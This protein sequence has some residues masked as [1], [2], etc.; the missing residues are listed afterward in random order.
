M[1]FRLLLLTTGFLASTLAGCGREELAPWFPLPLR[2]ECTNAP[3][4]VVGRFFEWDLQY[5]GGLEPLTWEAEGLPPGLMI[6]DGIISGTPTEAGAFD[7]IIRVTDAD[8][9]VTEFDACGRLNVNPP[10]RPDIQCV[11]ETG[12]MPGGFVGVPYNF[13]VNAPGGATPYTWEV[14]GLAPGLTLTPDGASLSSATISGTPTTTGVYP[15]T[16]SVTDAEGVV[17][18]ATCGDLIINDPIS[19]DP[20]ELLEV[21]PDGCVPLGVTLQDLINEGIIFGG[22][23]TAISC[24]FEASRGHGAI[25]GNQPPGLSLD[26]GTCAW[27]GTVSSNLPFGIYG[28][29]TTFSQSGQNAYVPHCAPQ[30]VK[31][32]TAYT[33]G[34]QDGG[35]DATFKPGVAWL[36]GGGNFTFGTD[37][38]DPQVTV[39]DNVNACNGNTCFYA[40]V[41]QYN[42]LSQMASVSANPNAKFPAQGFD[43]FTHAVRITDGT[44]DSLRSRAY[45]ANV[46]FDYC[47]ANNGD[48][49]GNNATPEERAILVRM[50]GGNSNYYFSLVVLPQN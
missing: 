7:F 28:Y 24:G 26:A 40:F 45:V 44:I 34:R 46:T 30:T 10:D 5:T 23:G 3:V 37:V 17:T 39:T 29:I 22:D 20:N 19:V 36:P 31:A 11:D 48:T 14:T 47:I 1:N 12:N 9:N 21:Y 33:V 4:A 38:P 16:I 27:S 18:T 32:P 35:V 6:A 13:V 42:T 49:C 25:D 41:F 50:N 43:G 15:V 8:G 2:I